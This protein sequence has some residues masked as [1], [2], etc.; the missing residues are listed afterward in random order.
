MGKI[1]ITKKQY[2]AILLHEQE[3][4]L[5]SIKSTINEEEKDKD[6]LSKEISD[7]VFILAKLLGKELTGQNKI[8]LEKALSDKA[9][10]KTLKEMLEDSEKTKKLIDALVSKGMNNPAEKIG[11][12]ALKIVDEFNKLD[13]EIQLDDKAIHNLLS[14]VHK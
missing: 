6:A 14:L 3:A 9:K 5:K 10:L 13:N 8:Y 12:N 1:K 2:E 4:R 11:K 7:L